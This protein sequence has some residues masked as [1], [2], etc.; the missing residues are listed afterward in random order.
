MRPGKPAV[1]SDPQ[2]PQSVL[3]HA[4]EIGADLWLFRRDFNYAGDRQQWSFGGR[5][6]RRNSLAYPAL[7]GANQLLNASGVLAALEAVRD[8]L[9]VSAQD[10]RRGFSL[11]DLPGRFQVLPG[12]PAVIL[13]V[14][15]NP[16]AA[17]HLVRN[18]QSMGFF[19][20]TYA[21]FGM[22]SDKDIDAVIAHLKGAVDH[23]ICCSLPGPRGSAA[24]DLAARLRA[25]GVED[26]SDPRAGID[27]SVVCV[28]T[29][30][31]GL[32]LARGKAGENDRILVFGSFLTVA[33]ALETLGTSAVAD[34]ERA[35]PM[36]AVA[37]AGR[38]Q[39][40]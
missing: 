2:P 31:Q 11:V 38:N 20:R 36:P 35:S 6:R 15:H 10:V 40:P 34:G 19:E 16:H 39:Q 29:A 9:P 24:Q 3:D 30:A 18:L 12:R 14:A 21:V 23:W 1:C 4:R 17:A 26:R 5:H 33:N 28:P 27:S 13:D 32:A 25:A 22:L 7:R 8:A 37:A